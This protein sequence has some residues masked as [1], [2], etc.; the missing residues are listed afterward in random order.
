M[1]DTGLKI[2]FIFTGGTI[3]TAVSEDGKRR[4]EEHGEG[5]MPLPLRIIRERLPE[6][7]FTA[8]IREPYLVLSE[9]MTLSHLEKLAA[10]LREEELTEYDGVMITHGS[11]TLAFTAAFLGELLRG[12]PVPVFLLAAQ[13]PMEDPQSNA[14]D[15]IRAA[16]ELTK[17]SK[18]NGGCSGVYVTYRNDDGAVYL[19]K[20]SELCQCRPGSDDFFSEGMQALIRT[21]AGYVWPE[22]SGGSDGLK[23]FRVPEISLKPDVLILHPYVGMRYDCISL[24]GIRAVLHTMYHSSTAPK[25]LE[26]FLDRCSSEG[27][28]CYILPCV[29]E[30]T[31]YE[32]TTGLIRHGAVPISGMTVES[33]YMKLLLA[34]EQGL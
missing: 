32:T 23:D 4:I 11:D 25:E 14:V 21:E 26:D 27:V 24:K 28:K 8:D 22:D 12:C 16:L 31:R 1:N 3:G 33:A 10:C 9:H 18:E 13:R 20:A 7:D 15:N 19:H 29:P 34:G 6:P 5:K 2:L 30:E 17:A